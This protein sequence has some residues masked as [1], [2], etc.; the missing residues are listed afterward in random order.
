MGKITAGLGVALVVLAGSFKLYY[1][2]TEAEKEQMALQL[3]QCADNQLLLENSIKGLNEQILQAEEDKKITFQKINLLQ[4][5]NRKS[6]EEVNN[7]KS[8]FDKHNMKN[9]DEEGY[10]IGR[11]LTT[12]GTQL[13]Y[14]HNVEDL[15][16]KYIQNLSLINR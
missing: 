14:D 5:Q 6:L 9:Y 8:K 10:Y 1:D 13:R 2:K 7:L 15:P 4:E 16:S 12:K 3:R 11:P